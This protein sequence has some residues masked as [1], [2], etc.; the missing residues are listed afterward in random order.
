MVKNPTAN[1][2][3]L[4]DAGPIPGWGRPWRR[5][6]HPTPAFLPGESQGQ[7][8]LEG[9]TSCRKLDTTDLTAE[10]HQ[11]SGFAPHQVVSQIC[12]SS[13]KVLSESFIHLL[14]SPTQK[15]ARKHPPGLRHTPSMG[16]RQGTRPQAQV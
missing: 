1:A 3:G 15:K 16:C 11:V 14:Q 9:C 13:C 8:R 2:G 7:R 10:H 4:R 12:P 5:A 6:W